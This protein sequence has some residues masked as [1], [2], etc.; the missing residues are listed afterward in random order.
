MMRMQF[1]KYVPGALIAAGSVAMAINGCAAAKDLQAGCDGLDV[2][3]S[4][5]LTVK[6]FADACTTLES[7]A[8]D[9]EAKFLAACNAMNSTLGEDTTQTT[10]DKACAVL[11]ARIDKAAAAGVTV[12]VQFAA[13]CTANVD[14]QA[15][16][17]A[18]CD[19]KAS[20]DVKASCEPG[21][22]VVACNGS[23]DAQCD[24]RAPDFACMGSCEGACTVSANAM[25][26]GTCEGS[27]DAPMF[28]G[29]CDVGCTASFSGTCEGTC[30]G[31]CDGTAMMGTCNGKCQGTCTGKATGTC[32]ATCTGVYTGPK[33]MGM[34]NGKCTVT[35]NA[36]C[37]GSC[38]GTC[39]YTP[40][41]AM[42][43]GECH[44]TCSAET[45]PPRC[46]GTVDCTASAE[47][48]GSCNASAKASIDCSHPVATVSVVGD[49]KLQ[50][51]LEA[52][53]GKWAEA[54]NLLASLK[55]PLAQLGGKGVATF[56]ALGDIG[57]AGISCVGS[58]LS[59]TASA[60]TSIM[61]SVNASASISANG[62]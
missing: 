27:C 52:N 51:A 7:R 1:L 23:C 29:T 56:Q 47:C 35:G 50:Q 30:D 39:S 33:C 25:C 12:T 11:K 57:T 34:C 6:A 21:K 31:M 32:A 54:V 13:N 16:C 38:N 3:V 15:D 20:C 37:S 46:T 61:V 44:G 10:A 9:V 60:S 4:A 62:G 59:A 5:Q 8:K 58:A 55:D 42:C 48:R 28:E 43:T 18:Q 24:V 22:L 41:T 36:M 40:G 45:K 53:I 49:L 26:S 14:V 17:E 19:A 2:N